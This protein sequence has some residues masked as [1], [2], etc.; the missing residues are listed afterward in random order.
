MSG[1]VV[2]AMSCEARSIVENNNAWIVLAYNALLSGRGCLRCTAILGRLCQPWFFTL[3]RRSFC[4]WKTSL[5]R[6]SSILPVISLKSHCWSEWLLVSA[7]SQLSTIAYIIWRRLDTCGNNHYYPE[8]V[9]QHHPY[10]SEDYTGTKSTTRTQ[11]FR[12]NCRS[13]SH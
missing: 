9:H 7:C 2:S 4:Q 1:E 11:Y 3:T 13:F 12:N 5:S 6:S 10:V 8:S